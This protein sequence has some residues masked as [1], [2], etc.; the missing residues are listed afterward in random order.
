[1]ED[2]ILFIIIG[3]GVVMD[4]AIIIGVVMDTATGIMVGVI[5]GDMEDGMG[6]NKGIRYYFWLVC[7]FILYFPIIAYWFVYREIL[8]IRLFIMDWFGF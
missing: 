3:V 2:I 1:M 6:D 4:T 7:Y 5:V 8:Y